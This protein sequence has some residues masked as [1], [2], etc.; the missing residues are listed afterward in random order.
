MYQVKVTN[1]PRWISDLH[2]KQRF[3]NCGNIVSA[4]IALDTHAPIPLG[5]GY[6]TF[7]NI[8]SVQKALALS[9]TTLDGAVISVKA[10]DKVDAI[11][12]IDQLEEELEVV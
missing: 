11:L 1:L 7:A 12:E 4:K 6:I 5:Y 9:G 3:L 2:L 10:V 8:E